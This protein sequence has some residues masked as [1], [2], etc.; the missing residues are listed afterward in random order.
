MGMAVQGDGED[1]KRPQCMRY[2]L[3]VR[4]FD[5][6]P[7]YA[8]RYGRQGR[9][10]RVTGGGTSGSRYPTESHPMLHVTVNCLFSNR[11][12]KIENP[13]GDKCYRL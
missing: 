7:P 2:R 3:W 1:Q 4:I 12:S 10:V 11:K 6:K 8:A 5:R 13:Y 9:T